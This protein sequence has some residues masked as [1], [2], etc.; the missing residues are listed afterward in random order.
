[1]VTQVAIPA[2]FAEAYRHVQRLE[3]QG[4]YRGAFIFGSVARGAA[5]ARSDLDVKVLVEADNPCTGVASLL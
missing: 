1:M 5:T 3:R 2:R 4:R